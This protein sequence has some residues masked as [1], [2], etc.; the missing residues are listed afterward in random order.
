MKMKLS[1]ARE[2]PS[3]RSEGDA[4]SSL[5]MCKFSENT[6]VFSKHFSKHF[7]VLEFSVL[8]KTLSVFK[9]VFIFPTNLRN[10]QKFVGDNSYLRTIF[11]IRGF[12]CLPGV[13]GTCVKAGITIPEC[14][15]YAI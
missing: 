11:Q 15:E 2:T 1:A 6:L 13:I 3:R 8:V 7:S 12:L 14:L 4:V 9:S 5:Y 10:A